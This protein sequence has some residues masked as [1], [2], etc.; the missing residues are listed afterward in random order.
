LENNPLLLA[1][2]KAAEEQKQAYSSKG[3]H[4]FYVATFQLKGS[5][6]YLMFQKDHLVDICEALLTKRSLDS[7]WCYNLVYNQQLF[8]SE[9]REWKVIWN[10]ILKNG[11]PYLEAVISSPNKG[12]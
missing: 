11:S 5:L 3:D 12:C 7:C 4:G 9:G 6:A 8:K 1:K 2:G 10:A